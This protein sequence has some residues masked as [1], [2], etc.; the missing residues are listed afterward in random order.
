M[1][2]L[3]TLFVWSLVGAVVGA[4]FLGVQKEIAATK[5]GDGVLKPRHWVLISV[6]AAAFAALAIY[7]SR[8]A[9]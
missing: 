7:E 2:L 8:F 6:V 9:S 1:T 5:V 3:V 4:I